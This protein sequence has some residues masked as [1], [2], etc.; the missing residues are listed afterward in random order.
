MEGV[1][2]QEGIELFK[3]NLFSLE[4]LVSGGDIARRWFPFLAR[5]GAFDGDSFAGHK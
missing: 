2:A 3:F 1:P 5:F 4:L